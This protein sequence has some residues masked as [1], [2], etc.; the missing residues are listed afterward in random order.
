V[1]PA[2]PSAKPARRRPPPS[3]TCSRRGSGDRLA[4]THGL[5]RAAG[6]PARPNILFVTIDC[7]SRRTRVAADGAPTKL[8]PRSRRPRRRR[9]RVHPVPYGCDL[10]LLVGHV[11][12][13]W[14]YAPDRISNT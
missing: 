12:L 9:D 14:A 11:R 3:P 7:P 4:T 13:S 5:L 8:T 2:A 1:A 10:D 6:M